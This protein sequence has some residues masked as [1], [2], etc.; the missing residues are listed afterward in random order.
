M[1]KKILYL[2]ESLCTLQSYEMCAKYTNESTMGTN[3]LVLW[4][5][6]KHVREV[7]LL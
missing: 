2:Y 4:G 3:H 5:M 1:F 6:S 7:I